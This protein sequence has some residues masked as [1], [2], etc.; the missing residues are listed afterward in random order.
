MK[1]TGRE[2]G[3]DLKKP[4][5]PIFIGGWRLNCCLKREV[6]FNVSLHHSVR[7]SVRHSI[8][9]KPA[10]MVFLPLFFFGFLWKMKTQQVRAGPLPPSARGQ[11]LRRGDGRGGRARTAQTGRRG[12][13]KNRPPI[14]WGAEVNCCFKRTS[15]CLSC[16]LYL[17]WYRHHWEQISIYPD[18]PL[19]LCQY[20]PHCH[21]PTKPS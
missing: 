2:G 17:H 5:P 11:A 20:H 15:L 4:P 7:H 21:L 18:L 13:K 1:N 19:L 9:D 16:K 8:P 14:Y 6:L 3:E 10:I 12:F